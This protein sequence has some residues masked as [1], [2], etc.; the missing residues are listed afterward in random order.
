MAH[1]DTLSIERGA[2]LGQPPNSVE[3]SSARTETCRHVHRRDSA[4]RVRRRRISPLLAH[5]T[6]EKWA[7]GEPLT[8]CCVTAA[9]PGNCAAQGAARATVPSAG[10]RPIVAKASTDNVPWHTNT[11]Q[12]NNAVLISLGCYIS[13]NNRLSLFRYVH[14]FSPCSKLQR[15]DPGHAHPFSATPGFIAAGISHY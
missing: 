2:R 9:L 8:G 13:A 4:K 14:Y 15:S 7:P 3:A 12:R 10:Y 11:R 5:R 6:H 1:R